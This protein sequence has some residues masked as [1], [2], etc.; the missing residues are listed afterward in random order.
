MKKI[1]ILMLT[2][3]IIITTGCQSK[4]I[5]I[6]YGEASFMI[7]VD[8]PREIA[9]WGDYVFVAKIEEELRTEYS[10]IR[11][12]ENGTKVGKPYTVYSITVTDNLKGKIQK[13]K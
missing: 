4:D 13:N 11:E 1:S 8:E 12:N 2:L 3:L 6:I 10:N 5:P 9:G 7:N